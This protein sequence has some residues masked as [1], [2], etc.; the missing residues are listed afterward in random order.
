MFHDEQ[1][2]AKTRRTYLERLWTPILTAVDLN[3]LKKFCF[4]RR[5]LVDVDLIVCAVSFDDC[6]KSDIQV[7]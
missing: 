6:T 1:E 4:V 3:P 5:L 2:C 7:L